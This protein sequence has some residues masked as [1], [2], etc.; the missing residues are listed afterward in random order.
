MYAIRSYYDVEM[1]HKKY[2]YLFAKIGN[3]KNVVCCI[4]PQSAI[5]EQANDIRT[6]TFVIVF[7]ASIVA[8]GLSMFMAIGMKKVMHELNLIV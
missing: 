8:I 7:L 4:I 5:L 1:D 3:T 2:L 6:F